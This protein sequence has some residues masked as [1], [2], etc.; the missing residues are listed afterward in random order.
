MK[1]QPIKRIGKI[2]KRN[3]DANKKLKEIFLEK[4]IVRCELCGTDNFLSFA[5]KHKRDWYRRYPEL[6]SDYNQVLL[7]CIPCHE[8]IEVNRVETRALFIRLRYCN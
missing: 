7:L 6:L 4:G 3:I 8:K 2:G 5:H 1:S